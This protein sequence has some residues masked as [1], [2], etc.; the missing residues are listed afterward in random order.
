M[1]FNSTYADC[2]GVMGHVIVKVCTYGAISSKNSCVSLIDTM[3]SVGPEWG[4]KYI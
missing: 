1:S 4:K 3:H 2:V